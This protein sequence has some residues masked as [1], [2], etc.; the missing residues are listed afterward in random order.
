[1]FL[2]TTQTF[3]NHCFPW[4]LKYML[5][6]AVALSYEP[7]THRCH[8][9]PFR[10]C[11]GRERLFD[12]SLL[13]PQH[14]WLD[15]H[16]SYLPLTISSPGWVTLLKSFTGGGHQLLTDFSTL[17]LPKEHLTLFPHW[18][19]LGVPRQWF[20]KLL[21]WREFWQLPTVGMH[22]RWSNQ[23][24]CSAALDSAEVAPRFLVTL[25]YAS[26]EATICTEK[27]ITSICEY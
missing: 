19:V 12:M 22:T 2:E 17:T 3:S 13:F 6:R 1:M 7:D 26:K 20:I 5:Y 9:M 18:V 25:C 4:C 23:W 24:Q 8:S 10:T 16:P 21:L 27:S 11:N 15:M 14:S